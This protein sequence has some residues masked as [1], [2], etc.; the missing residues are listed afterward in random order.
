MKLA[1]NRVLVPIRK[2][3]L[4]LSELALPVQFEKTLPLAGTAVKV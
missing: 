2:V 3:S 4:G 1:C